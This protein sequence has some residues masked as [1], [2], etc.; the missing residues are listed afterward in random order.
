P[1]TGG[2]IVYITELSKELAKAGCSVDIFTRYFKDP[3]W[4]GYE[5]EIEEYNKNLRIIRIKCGPEDKFINKEKL[6]PLINDFTQGAIDYY[7]SRSIEPD[8][9]SSHYADAGLSAAIM[10]KRMFKAFT[11]TGHSLGGKKM[12]NLKLSRSNFEMINKNFNFHLRVAAERVSF[13]NAQAIIASTREEIEKQYGHRVYEGAVED[14]NKFEVIPPGI[15][16]EQFFSYEKGEENKKTYKKAVE[17]LQKQLAGGIETGRIKLP[18]VFSAARFDA[19]K[20]PTGLLRA[21]ASSRLLQENTNLL[22]IAGNIEDPL[23]PD[24]RDKFKEHEKYIIEDIA[25]IIKG[26]NLEGKV[27]LSPGFDYKD[28]MPYIYRYAARNKW[29]F[30]NPALHEPF[31]L[32]IVEA[33]A[34][35]L[36]VV[37]TKRGGPAE[38]LRAGDFGILSETSE[39][40]SLSH[41][42]E[43][44][45]KKER[46]EKYSEKGIE[47]VKKKFTWS[48]A[49]KA[50]IKL[51]KKI[52]DE[53]VRE[54]ND[55]PVPGYFLE[56]KGEKDSRLRS[57]LRDLLFT[58]EGK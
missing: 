30:V 4:P 23:N 53:G 57:E 12:D 2:Q 51:F 14:R 36:P 55:F 52:I 19:K 34:S 37:A 41:D 44:L 38:I 31:G 21:Y 50:Y 8:I 39:P 49:A 9:V 35:G 43:K 56:K 27:C 32:T 20:N 18:C 48:S 26:W 10:K 58:Q 3:K 6:W 47:R 24:N 54:K 7:K 16:P 15:G 17:K 13:R 40:L 46:W 25:G 5:K 45:L 22:I 28:E 11:H 33:M 42:I 29:V 1:D